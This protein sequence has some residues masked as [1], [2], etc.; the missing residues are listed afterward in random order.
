MNLGIKRWTGAAAVTAVLIT[1]VLAET[2]LAKREAVVVPP[3]AKAIIRAQMDG[4]MFE[5]DRLVTALAKGD[6]AEAASAADEMSVARGGDNGGELDAGPGLGI[7]QYLPDG[8]KERGRRLHDSAAAYARLLRQ[9]ET[10]AMAA[11]GAALL[12]GLARITNQCSACHDAYTL[13]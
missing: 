1:P 2:T 7:G 5:L 6:Y 11:D 8:F 3:E 4:H 9:Y 10:Q 13:D 12:D